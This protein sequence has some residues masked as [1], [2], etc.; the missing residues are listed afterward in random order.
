MFRTKAENSLGIS[1]AATKRCERW[2]REQED[3]VMRAHLRIAHNE[4]EHDL[5]R[6]DDHDETTA[7]LCE[8]TQ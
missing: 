1:A 3:K 7:T 4:A 2:Q 6:D 5:D 8:K